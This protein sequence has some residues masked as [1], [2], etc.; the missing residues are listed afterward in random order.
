MTHFASVPGNLTEVWCLD[1]HAGAG[2][3]G[4]YDW[5]PEDV[6][7]LRDA[8]LVLAADVIYDDD[9]TLAFMECMERFLL[10]SAGCPGANGICVPHHLL[11]INKGTLCNS[12]LGLC[13]QSC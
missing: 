1:C 8:Q 3:D 13:S 6:A 5:L 10:P 9:L 2:K 7:E 4:A 11:W 12:S